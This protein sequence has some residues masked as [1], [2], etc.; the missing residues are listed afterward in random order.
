MEVSAHTAGASLCAGDTSEVLDLLQET[1]GAE[2]RAGVL[3]PLTKAGADALSAVA[4]DGACLAALG[5][6]MIDLAQEPHAFHVLEMLLK[7]SDLEHKM[8]N[9]HVP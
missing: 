9:L 7:A 5:A 2:A 1:V 8:S 6:W 3:G 4:E